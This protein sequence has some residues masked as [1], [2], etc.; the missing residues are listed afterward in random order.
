MV[1]T[2]ETSTRWLVVVSGKEAAEELR[3]APENELSLGGEVKDVSLFCWS[4]Q[5]PPL[6]SYPSSFK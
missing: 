5:R 3:R 6:T 2:F 1:A 4:I